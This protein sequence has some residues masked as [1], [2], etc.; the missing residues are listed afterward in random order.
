MGLAGVWRKSLASDWQLPMALQQ[1]VASSE[2]ITDDEILEKVQ[3]TARDSPSRPR[4]MRW[5]TRTFP[6]PARR[7]AAKL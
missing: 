4:W 5:A 2:A 3:Q 6:L 7:A 1:E